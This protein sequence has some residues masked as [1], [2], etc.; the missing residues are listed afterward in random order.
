MRSRAAC[1]G[2]SEPSHTT[3]AGLL[4][5]MKAVTGSAARLVWVAPEVIEA[6]GIA[7]WTEL[8]VWV[9]PDSELA[10]MHTGD[11]TAAR[12]AGLSCRPVE[13]TVADTWAWLRAEGDPPPRPGRPAPGLDPGREL[14]AL[15]L[16]AL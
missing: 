15:A 14:R 16:A 6:A 1:P 11:V 10:S 4:E 3:M 13:E 5:A 7:P 12:A 9:P 8:P 2:G